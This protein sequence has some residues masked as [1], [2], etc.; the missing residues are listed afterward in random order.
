M[1]A[2]AKVNIKRFG[3]HACMKSQNCEDVNAPASAE[4]EVLRTFAEAQIEQ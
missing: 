1:C 3:V 4:N 2:K